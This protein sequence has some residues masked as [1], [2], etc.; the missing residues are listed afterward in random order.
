M[1]LEGLRDM[2][3]HRTM[4]CT[5]VLS[6]KAI[7]AGSRCLVRKRMWSIEAVSKS[8]IRISNPPSL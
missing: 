6:H 2:Q 5:E 3:G 1:M 4:L 8:V 7:G